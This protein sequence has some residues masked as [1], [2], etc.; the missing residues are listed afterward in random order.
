MPL[1]KVKFTIP[2]GWNVSAFKNADSYVQHT[3]ARFILWLTSPVF[4]VPYLIK[5]DNVPAS[6]AALLPRSHPQR[7]AG[8][9][10]ESTSGEY[11][12]RSLRQAQ[13]RRFALLRM[14]R[15]QDAS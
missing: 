11:A 5:S 3:A 2:H 10:P 4:T 1:H 12:T 8:S 13:G 7:S 15:G 9:D 6:R 14:A